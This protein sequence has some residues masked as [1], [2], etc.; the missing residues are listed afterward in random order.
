MNTYSVSMT[1]RT[2]LRGFRTISHDVQGFDAL[3]ASKWAAKQY[4]GEDGETL[5]ICGATEND[6]V[7]APVN[8][9]RA[10]LAEM[11]GGAE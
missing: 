5:I 10:R 11:I 6:R 8:P 7:S 2:A 9:I 3:D 1:Y 4:P